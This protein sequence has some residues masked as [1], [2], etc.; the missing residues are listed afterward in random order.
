MLSLLFVLTGAMAGV[1][2]PAQLRR[3]ERFS[4]RALDALL[5]CLLFSTSLTFGLDPYVS[6]S[7]GSLGLKS[8]ISCLFSVAGSV[9]AT[10]LWQRAFRFPAV[11]TLEPDEGEDGE[12]KP[13]S[14]SPKALSL[15]VLFSAALGWAMGLALSPPRSPSLRAW[16]ETTSSVSLWAMLVLIGYDL[17]KSRVWH[18]MREYGVLAFSLPLAIAAGTLIGSAGAGLVTRVPLAEVL[19]AGSGFGWYSMA[20]A[21][22]LRQAGAET[23]AY[24]FLSNLWRELLTVAIVPFFAGRAHP[25][26]GAA[27][28]GATAMDSTLPAI[29]RSLGTQA[30]PWALITGTTLSALSPFALGLFL[31]MR[32]PI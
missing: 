4:G 1:R 7:L 14:L 25:A 15:A 9:G 6:S 8:F 12:G 11:S 20:G 21:T 3:V 13:P 5:L 31:K 2:R 29:K 22:A 27:L 32:A 18:E 17:G 23:G 30:A 26:L 28:G 24:V 10:V 19:A 16:C